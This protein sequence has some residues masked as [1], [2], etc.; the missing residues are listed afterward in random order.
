MP[1]IP[2]N[3]AIS[4]LEKLGI[5]KHERSMLSKRSLEGLEDLYQYITS[6]RHRQNFTVNP[7]GNLGWTRKTKGFKPFESAAKE[8]NIPKKYA[9]YK[10]DYELNS[11]KSSISFNPEGNYAGFSVQS[12]PEVE[13]LKFRPGD[14]RMTYDGHG[15]YNI[16]LTSPKVDIQDLLSDYLSSNVPEEVALGQALQSR[17]SNT[18]PKNTMRHFWEM[19]EQFQKPGTYL[20]GDN[21]KLPIGA[22]YIRDFNN[23]QFSVNS[24]YTNPTLTTARTGLSPDSYS[25]IIRQAQREG[26]RLRWGEGFERWNDSAVVNRHI[27]DAWKRYTKGELPLEEYEQ[28]FNNWAQEIGGEPLIIKNIPERVEQVKDNLG[29]ITEQII[30]ARTKV[31]HPH[32]YVYKQ[33]KGGI[34]RMI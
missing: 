32:P 29:N 19:A 34:I 30:P 26:K 7:N 27:Y 10:G 16:V 21:G 14:A 17:L 18:I 23:K 33:R 15:G 22:S 12:F 31:I 11:G 6:G 24:L 9:F 3:R 28:I 5:P 2:I 1:N 25:S 8:H 13:G 20:S 4:V